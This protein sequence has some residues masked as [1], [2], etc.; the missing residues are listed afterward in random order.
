VEVWGVCQPAAPTKV[1]FKK[2][3][4]HGFC[5]HNDIKVLRELP[6]SLNQQVKSADD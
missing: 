4:K 6:F 3:K 2:K 1:K 5:R